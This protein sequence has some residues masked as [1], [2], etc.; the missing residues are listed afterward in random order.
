MGKNSRA[1]LTSPLARRLGASVFI[2]SVFVTIVTSCLYLYS[3]LRVGIEDIDR[4]IDEVGDI[5]L[6]G[7]ASR[8][9][10]SDTDAIKLDFGGMLNLQSIE[11][12]A[13]TEGG[14]ILIEAGRS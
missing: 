9:W 14:A 4:Q 13:I 8:L 3:Q 7:I 10:V 2:V 5:Y 11:Y 1:D 12:L 6:P